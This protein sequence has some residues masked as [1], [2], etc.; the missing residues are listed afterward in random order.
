MTG[1]RDIVD[2]ALSVVAMAA[3]MALVAQSE[4]NL[5]LAAGWAPWIAWAAPIA[6]DAYVVRAV[7]ARRDLGPAI[8][9]SAVS[10]LAS[11]AV[12]AAPTAWTSGH[13]GDGHLRPWLA[14]TCSVVPLL[15]AWRGHYIDAPARPVTTRERRPVTVKADTAPAVTSPMPPPVTADR[16]VTTDRVPRVP[17]TVDDLVL[18]A[19]AVARDLART[20]QK[21]N[22]A[23]LARGLRDRG[24]A[25]STDKAQALMPV[26][27]EQ[28]EKTA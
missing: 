12:Y 9:V 25:C 2:R 13:V 8:L 1:R 18:P 24:H 16:P 19:Q 27:R 10:V 7:R 17:V 20:G 21:V 5:A 28:L 14:A 11:H 22:R 23:N 6:L 15:V 3:A 4:W 26:I